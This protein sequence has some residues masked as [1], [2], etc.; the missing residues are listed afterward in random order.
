[1]EMSPM[2]MLKIPNFEYYFGADI[3]E[4]VCPG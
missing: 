2:E 4:P 3:F 1:M